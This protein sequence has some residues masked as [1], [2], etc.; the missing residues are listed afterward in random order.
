MSSELIEHNESDES[1]MVNLGSIPISMKTVQSIYNEITGKTESN[2][3]TLR[4]H[5]EISFSDI[6]QLDLKITQL[7]E[8]YNV[9]SHTCAVTIYHIDDRKEQ[10]SSFQ[11][12]ELYDSSS[13]SPCENIRLEYNFLIVLPST[14]KAQPY[15]IEIDLHSRAALREK[16]DNEHGLQKRISII[17][18]T[19]TGRF[20]IEYVDYTVAR[21]F[22]VAFE[23]W[24][25]GVKKNKGSRF[26]EYLQDKSEHLPLIF[27]IISSFVILTVFYF[28][29]EV[30]LGSK[31]SIS[32]LFSSSLIAFGSV[33][34]GGMI[35]Y[36]IGQICERVIDAQQ[37][38]SGLRLNRG[39][40]SAMS[41]F[42]QANEKNL[43]KLAISLLGLIATNLISSY[44]AKILGIG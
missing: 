12:F 39:D 18:A 7:Y 4:S 31:P 28:H 30:I 34:V 1:Q 5:H 44:A 32:S 13:S 6:K 11:R 25:S 15:K 22:E 26:I 36:K 27:K 2:S 21:N 43:W 42:K 23:H 37:T 10:F 33:Y 20:S 3:K 16:S 19:R 24:Y 8:Q 9:V 29:R 14:R 40:E 41:A 35:S 38:V 17:F